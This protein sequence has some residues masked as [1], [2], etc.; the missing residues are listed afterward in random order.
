MFF[1]QE[2]VVTITQTIKESVLMLGI[3][4]FT[5]QTLKKDPLNIRDEK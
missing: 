5:G 4:L 3:C 2:G 1:A